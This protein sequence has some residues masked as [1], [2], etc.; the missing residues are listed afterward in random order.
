MTCCY[1]RH[2]FC[3]VCL[4]PWDGAPHD[5][6][7]CPSYGDP[8][9]GYDSEGYE[10]TVRGLHRDTGYD[11]QG[12]NRFGRDR[13]DFARG[14]E[15]VGH[16]PWSE[17]EDEEDDDDATYYYAGGNDNEDEFEGAGYEEYVDDGENGDDW[18]HE[19]VEGGDEWH[20]WPSDAGGV[21]TDEEQPPNHDTADLEDVEQ[22]PG[23][24]VG[25]S[26]GDV[27]IAFDE[28][29]SSRSLFPPLISPAAASLLAPVFDDGAPT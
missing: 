10:L 7:G 9:A 11:R 26:W 8:P 27:P 2:D 19:H 18:Y 3:F 12:L 15:R 4:M 20:G 21:D 13:L 14:R 28:E 23:G 6:D 29:A 17:D 24:I 1:C 5:G 22:I 25:T 16:E